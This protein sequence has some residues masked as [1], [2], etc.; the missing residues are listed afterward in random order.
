MTNIQMT[1]ERSIDHLLVLRFTDFSLG[2]CGETVFE[3]RLDPSQ[4]PYFLQTVVQQG[5]IA[6]SDTA[7]TMMFGD[8]ERCKN[9]RL[10][11]EPVHDKTDRTWR[12]T[13]PDCSAGVSAEPFT[14]YPLIGGGMSDEKEAR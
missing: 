7:K 10:I 3:H 6:L 1:I 13:C 11:E 9:I 12:V 8:C 4:I 5:T 14:V 2:T